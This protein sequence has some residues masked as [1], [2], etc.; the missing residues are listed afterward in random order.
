MDASGGQKSID[1]LA[2]AGQRAVYSS[3]DASVWGVGVTGD[4]T[5]GSTQVVA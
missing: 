5:P 4:G 1:P 2:G 3:Q